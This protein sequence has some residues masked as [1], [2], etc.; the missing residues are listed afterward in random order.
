[1]SDLLLFIPVLLLC[2]LGILL[3]SL[4]FSGTWIVF[5]AAVIAYL[6]AGVPSLGALIV[7]VVLCIFAE[8][9]EAVAGYRGV[10]KR[11]GS[12][13]A[14]FAALVGG[15]IGAG[16]GTAI[17]PII[18]TLLGILLGSF[19]LAYFAEWL[20]LKH[21][22][23]AAHIALGALW[24]RLSIMLFKSVLTIGMS[25]WLLLRLLDGAR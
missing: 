19:A 7:F 10:Q 18:G 25:V 23:K 9:A 15:L 5:G 13:W 1:M 3:S 2:L 24:A 12:K 17:L 4:A 6:T 20:R 14:G 22:G 11:G 16:A 21:H 8:L